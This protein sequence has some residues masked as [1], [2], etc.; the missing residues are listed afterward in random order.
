[1]LT[2][3]TI[4]ASRIKTFQTCK[5]KYYL[6][7]HCPEVTL[8]TN[9]GATHGSML[10]DILENYASERDINWEA[11]LLSA[12]AGKIETKDKTGN[13]VLIDSPLKLAKSAEFAEQE[14]AC[15][16]C[17]FVDGMHCGISGEHLNHLSGCPKKLYENSHSVIKKAI[18]D[19]Q[20]IWKKILRD[21]NNQIIGTE[22]EYSIPISGTEV[23]AIG[24][25]DLVVEDDSDTIHII[26][27]KFGAWTQNYQDCRADIQVRMYSLAA[28]KIFIDDILNLGYKYKNVI[29]TFDYFTKD[30]ITLSFSKEEDFQTEM[31]VSKIIKEIQSTDS[32]DR[33]VNS[34]DDFEKKFAW[35]CRSLCDTKI[36][37]EKWK[38]RLKV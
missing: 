22:Y 19:Y 10:H 15:D 8:K 31:E 29:L 21:K 26:D 18:N 1:M 16:T 35:K 38:G 33:I 5:F 2:L 27:Y 17:K 20:S 37:A 4:S 32:I 3:K 13:V 25:M 11:R 7:Y 36:C 24:F 6:N 9:F 12:Y 34:N 23:Q 28:R 30:P 14:P